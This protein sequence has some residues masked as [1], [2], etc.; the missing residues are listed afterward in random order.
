MGPQAKHLDPLAHMARPNDVLCEV[1]NPDPDGIAIVRLG[2]LSAADARG[3]MLV[4][5]DV[6]CQ[7]PAA[8]WRTTH[9]GRGQCADKDNQGAGAELGTSTHAPARSAG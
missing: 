4:D 1:A 2:I 9:A 7:A 8:T 6:A 5:D 3:H